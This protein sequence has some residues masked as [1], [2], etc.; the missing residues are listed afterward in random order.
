MKKLKFVLP[1]LAAILAF[2]TCKDDDEDP[3]VETQQW[4]FEASFNVTDPDIYSF[5]A[6]G[7]A[8]IESDGNTYTIVA[9]YTVGQM[10]FE[11]ITISGDIVDGKVDIT[12][13]V[14]VIE[15]EIN[16]I[17]YTETVTFSLSNIDTSGD[18][19]SGSGPF[20]I[21]MEPGAVEESGTLE[22]GATKM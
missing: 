9:T 16:E 5:T 20:E 14:V 2:S 1:L 4:E 11:D 12:N 21:V 13:K 10:E 7:T 18:T 3:N 8:V 19:A 22:F 17:Q 15:F 6:E